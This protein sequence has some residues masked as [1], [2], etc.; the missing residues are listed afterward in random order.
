MNK[1]K[2]TTPTPLSE[3]EHTLLWMSVR[4][5]CRRKTIASACL[6]K[7]IVEKWW[8]R[9]SDN[10][11]RAIYRDLKRELDFL[12]RIGGDNGFGDECDN[13]VWQKFMSACN[14]DAYEE[15]TLVDGTTEIVFRANNT[16][17]P[18]KSY[19]ENPW[20][21]IYIPEDIIKKGE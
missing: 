8:H 2:D 11:K 9:I 21:E 5:A 6:P 18:L 15:V 4:Y 1:N 14:V 12:T 19:I 16:I 20:A 7:E 17:Y 10:Q 3:F 13:L